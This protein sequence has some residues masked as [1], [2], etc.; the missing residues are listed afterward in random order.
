MATDSLTPKSLDLEQL[1]QLA[2]RLGDHADGIE[3]ITAH[4]L[5]KDIRTA[6]TVVEEHASWRFIIGEVAATLPWEN[7]AKKELLTLIGKG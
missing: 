5:E 1:N 4:Q 6:V 2:A 3:N 7:P